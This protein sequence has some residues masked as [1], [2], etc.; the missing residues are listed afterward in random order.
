MNSIVHFIYSYSLNRIFLSLGLDIKKKIFKHIVKLDLLVTKKMSV[1]EINF[2]IF[3]DSDLL[4]QSFGQ[5]MFGGL[6][7][8][9]LLII[10]FIYMF[11]ISSVMTIFVGVMNLI[12][13]PIIIYFT[14]RIRA[15][16]YERKVVTEATL[17]RTI[18]VISSFH[19]L[20]GC[21]NEKSEIDKFDKNNEKVLDKQI[22][23]ANLNLLFTE[24]SSVIMSC[25]GFGSIWI[26]GNFVINGIITMGELISFLL[27]ANIINSPINSI[28]S[29]ITGLQDALSSTKR[30]SDVMKLENSIIQSNDCIKVMH[31]IVDEITIKDL[32]FSYDDGKEVLKDI[33]LTVKKNTICSIIGRSG[34]GKTT[35]CLLIARFFDPS[36]G[37]ILLD[38]VNIKDI[39]VDTYRK[40]VGIVL[41]NSF[42]FSGSIREN[43]L[44]GKSDATEEEII[45]AAK[46]ANAHEFISELEDGYW[47]QI[48]SKGRNLSGGQLQRI[49]LARIFLQRPQIVILDEPTSFID[50]ESEELIQESINKL[51]EYSTI[52][53]ISHKLSTVKGSNKIVV[54]NNGRIEESGTHLQLL[55]KEGE[56]SKLYRKILA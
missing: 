17:N 29:V 49:A 3:N 35:L 23:E 30:I 9:I 21:N 52:F 32:N 8:V 42:L 45:E 10:I 2:R 7:N 27:V 1:G 55:E 25:I 31:K 33:N 24:I 12:Q 44:L 48:G 40:S 46:L 13:V 56:Y 16:T 36:S 20:K 26:G 4:K 18:E 39:D 41:Q 28:V 5:I 51:K 22:K 19:L 11:T 47:T 54:L 6:F 50:S 15:I 14:K 37:E 38:D 43:I 53:V 34:A